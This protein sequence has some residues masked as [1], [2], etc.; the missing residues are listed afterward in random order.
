MSKDY[1]D[2]DKKLLETVE[3]AVSGDYYLSLSTEEPTKADSH[4]VDGTDYARIK[5]DGPKESYT[6]P[7]MTYFSNATVR[8]RGKHWWNRAK[9]VSLA[10]YIKS[11]EYKG[12]SLG[13]K[14]ALRND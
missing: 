4:E 8:V 11:A 14:R 13:I 10:E 1:R 12:Y 5:R 7:S 6:W 9:T 2:A 3:K